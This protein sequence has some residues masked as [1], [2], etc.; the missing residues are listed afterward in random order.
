MHFLTWRDF[1]SII[2]ICY[3]SYWSMTFLYDVI[4]DIVIPLGD[5]LG[6]QVCAFV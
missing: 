6:L 5:P 2:A 1:F 4:V 3:S